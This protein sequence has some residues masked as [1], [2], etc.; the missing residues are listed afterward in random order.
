MLLIRVYDFV[1]LSLLFARLLTC[2]MNSLST[3][4]L[5]L[6]LARSKPYLRCASFLSSVKT[7][8]LVLSISS[9]I[10]Y[11]LLP[12]TWAS[13][14]FVCNSFS[15]DF[16]RH[17]VNMVDPSPAVSASAFFSS[18]SSSL[19]RLPNFFFL[20]GSFTGIFLLDIVL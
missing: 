11:V 17:L 13:L 10:L 19:G 20:L 3:V 4:A 1:M 18:F 2:H 8:F 14:N 7:A 9:L 12:E 15:L 5:T 16:Y 6:F